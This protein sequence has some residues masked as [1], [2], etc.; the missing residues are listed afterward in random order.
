MNGLSLNEANAF[1]EIP[2]L[3]ALSMWA[4]NL[5]RAR[6]PEE[7]YR[8]ESL[9]ILGEASGADRVTSSQTSGRTG[10]YT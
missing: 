9:G 7:A 4:E 3:K 2:H 5:I 8:R 1:R 10:N 6:K